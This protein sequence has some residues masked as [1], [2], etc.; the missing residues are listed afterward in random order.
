MP[1]ILRIDGFKIFFYSNEGNEPIHIHA[2]Y[3]GKNSKFWIVPEIKLADNKDMNSKELKK[4]ET[5]LNENKEKIVE[6]WN[7]FESRK[8]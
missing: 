4:L 1:V 5:I 7:E 3:S 6:A 2:V 8:K